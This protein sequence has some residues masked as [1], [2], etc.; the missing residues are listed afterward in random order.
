MAFTEEE[1]AALI[2]KP[3]YTADNN[4]WEQTVKGMPDSVASEYQITDKVFSL[5]AEE[6]TNTEYGFAPDAM[7]PSKTRQMHATDYAYAMGAWVGSPGELQGNCWWTLRTPGDGTMARKVALGYRDGRIYMEGYYPYMAKYYGVVPACYVAADSEHIV[8]TTKKEEQ[9]DAS[10]GPA[11]SKPP[12]ASIKPVPSGEPTGAAV[13]LGDMDGNGK[14]ELKDAQLVLKMA[15]NLMPVEKKEAAD[16]D[17]NGKIELKDAQLILKKALNLIATF[18]AE[19]NKPAQNS[20][21]PA[22]VQP[23]ESQSQAPK[24]SEAATTPASQAP[25]TQPE[26]K[27]SGHIWIAG[28]SIAAEHNN[29]DSVDANTGTDGFEIKSEWRL[30]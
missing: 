14:V 2:A 9:P 7:T 24:P 25:L 28:D 26:D 3:V 5:S 6:A 27:A 11:G 19:E 1:Q 22:S 17:G 21:A 30:V 18:P 23:S 8:K 29:E 10:E 20:E 12:V 15:L 16:V 4:F 13:T